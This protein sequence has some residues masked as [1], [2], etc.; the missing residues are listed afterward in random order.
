MFVRDP[1]GGGERMG[2]VKVDHAAKIVGRSFLPTG[3]REGVGS[4]RVWLAIGLALVVAGCLAD[5]TAPPSGRPTVAA[6]SNP[7]A[8]APLASAARTEPSASAPLAIATPEPTMPPG[9]PR[10]VTIERDGLRV[11]LE[12]E[13]NPMSAGEATWIT[14]TVQNVGAGPIQFFPCGEAMTASGR[15]RDRPWRPGAALPVPELEWKRY[16]LGHVGDQ[17]DDRL[18]I[19]LPDGHTGSSSGCGDVAHIEI[20]AAGDSLLERAR[21]DGLTFRRLAPPPTSRIDL[22]GSFAYAHAA[23]ADVEAPRLEIAIHLEAWIAGRPEPYLDPGEVADIA[24]RDPR[25]TAVLAARDLYNGNESVLRFDPAL[26]TY[27][28]GMLESGDLPIAQAHMLT[29][30]AVTGEILGFVERDWDYTVDGYP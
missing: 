3:L 29:I 20:L 21:W 17:A 2:T 27:E 13:R 26:R 16:L 18:V 6:A 1:A 7:S 12:L 23:Q 9:L 22:I 28:V 30:D 4:S 24:L 11:T 14:K 5:R 10:K 19:F 25:M 15:V 8:S